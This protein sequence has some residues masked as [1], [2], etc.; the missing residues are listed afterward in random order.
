MAAIFRTI[1]RFLKGMRSVILLLFLVTS[2]S[3]NVLLI[4]SD[5]VFD[6]VSGLVAAAT[7]MIAPKARAASKVAALGRDLDAQKRLNLDLRRQTAKANAALL[8]EQNAK[9]ELKAQLAARG[10]EAAIERKAAQELKGDL[11][12]KSAQLAAEKVARQRLNKGL[13]KITL[14]VTGRIATAAKRET[15]AMVGEAIPGWGVA[16]IISA[17]TLELAD[18]C[19]TVIDMKEIEALISTEVAPNAADFTVCGAVVPS[20]AELWASVVQAPRSAW[21]MGTAMLPSMSDIDVSAVDWSSVGAST[22]AG[23]LDLGAGLVNGVSGAANATGAK[24]G[25]FDRWLKTP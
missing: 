9:R 3:F 20:K 13:S 5:A 24:L 2:L 6:T 25:Q 23:T 7:G 19:Q 1:A 11:A 17:T 8:T 12:I 16:V 18:F 15:S 10:A 14:R 21:D 4:A 22:W